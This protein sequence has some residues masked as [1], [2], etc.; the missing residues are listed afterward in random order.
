MVTLHP[1]ILE[2]DGKKEFAV[3]PY[4]EYI[5]VQEELE[6]Y[7]ALKALREAKAKEGDAPTISFNDAKKELGIK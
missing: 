5:M 3:L 7:E 6:D 2:K 4:E 1:K